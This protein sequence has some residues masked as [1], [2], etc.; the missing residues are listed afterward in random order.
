M[1]ISTQDIIILIGLSPA[2]LIVI[3]LII[4]VFFFYFKNE[5]F[6][7]MKTNQQWEKA[8]GF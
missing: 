2:V 1:K 8:V 5:N 3:P 4:V 7:A 6:Y